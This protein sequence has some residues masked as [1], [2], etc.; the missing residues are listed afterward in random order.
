MKKDYDLKTM[1][2]K[3]RGILPA[4]QKEAAAHNK[5]RITI[6]LD[7][8]VVDYFKTQAQ[9][10]G[11]L[12]YQT[13]INRALRQ[14][15]K[16]RHDADHDSVAELKTELLHDSAFIRELAKKLGGKRLGKL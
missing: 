10:S 12:P 6:A 13:Q 3:R 1:K 2:V 14:L 16:Q 5:I 7:K 9:S 8:E 4:L 11:A 15:M